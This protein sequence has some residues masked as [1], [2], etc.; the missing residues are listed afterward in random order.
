M[1]ATTELYLG[2]LAR[3]IERLTEVVEALALLQTLRDHG[4]ISH[5]DLLVYSRRDKCRDQLRAFVEDL[6]KKRGD[7]ETP[8]MLKR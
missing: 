2:R 5:A 4:Q 8:E 6:A 7:E 3:K 1:D